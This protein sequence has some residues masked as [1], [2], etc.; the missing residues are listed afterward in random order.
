VAVS[1]LAFDLLE[2]PHVTR[3]APFRFAYHRVRGPYQPWARVQTL[4]AVAE[5]LE[6]AEVER[7]GPAFGIYYD[8]PWSEHEDADAWTADLGHPVAPGAR[9]PGRPG[10]RLRDVPD[11]R[12]AALRYRGDL[13][14]FPAALQ[15]LVEWTEEAGVEA[16]G[17]LLERFHVSDALTGAEERDVMLALD[18]VEP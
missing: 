4:D 17:P 7:A 10:L 1:E 6:R 8:L 5:T 12:V 11:V 3:L 2:E 13:G 16:E 9:V 18:P 15:Q 14:S